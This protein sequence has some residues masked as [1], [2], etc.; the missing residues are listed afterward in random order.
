MKLI[1]NTS[2]II[3]FL[4]A[5]SIYFLLGTVAASAANEDYPKQMIRLESSSGLNIT[6]AGNQDNAPLTTK[7]T[8]GEKEE[9]WRLDT[10]DGKQFKIRNM[11]SGKIIIPAH[12]ALSDHNPAVVYY[13]NSR[14][15]ELWNIIGADKDG[16][17]DFITYK[18]VSAQNNSLALTLDGSGVK[19]AKYTGS[20]LQK[21]KLPSDG[22][23]GFAGYAK[24]TNGKQKTG[25]SGGLLG[26]VVYVNNLGELK[27]NIEGSTPR[28]IVVSSN[29]GASAKTVLT[30]GANKT[31]IG[32][33]EKHKLNN[34][35]FKTKADSGNVIFKN[36]VIAHDASINENNDIPVYITDSR[37]Y[38]ID[39]V[40]FQGHS[41]SANG[42]DLDK[43][44]YV[45]AKADYVTLSHSTF[46][47]HRYGLI[48]G[49]PQ[50]DKQY[51]SIY[52]G[53]PRMTI[54]HNRFEN[55]Y[56]RA[57]GLMRYGYF[58][59]K[60]NYINNYHLGFT[61]TTL[62]KIYSEA[63][64]FGTGSEKGILDDY[65][66]GSFKDVGSYPAIKGQKSTETNW[67]PSS[68]YSYRT[69]KAGNAK[70]F[71]ER[72]AGAQRTALYYANYSQ[73]KND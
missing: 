37:N 66:D 26:K 19:L 46:T 18:I 17:G 67:R 62:A 4:A 64:Y 30:V 40:T 68:N 1:K 50:D 23:E 53:Y 63:N 13:D 22:L 25:T 29:I 39:H 51:H 65:G 61:I 52:N 59:A 56:V 73:F 55:L 28:T 31:I 57:P 44:L 49:W 2:F 69:M 5:A 38:W 58:H 14:K 34:V 21:W 12:Y 10:S 15:E 3:S 70:T 6:P 71:A 32:S 9:R 54:S 42:H 24:E 41:Y 72:Y 8:S 33:Y 16:N 45:G 48:L 20:S 7:Q 27:T 11:D 43:L 35:Y 47:D 36:L 60:N